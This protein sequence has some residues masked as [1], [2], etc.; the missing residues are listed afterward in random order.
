[1]ISNIACLQSV[2]FCLNT[3]LMLRLSPNMTCTVISK[4]LLCWCWRSSVTRNWGHEPNCRHAELWYSSNLLILL[5]FTSYRALCSQDLLWR[6]VLCCAIHL[7]AS[8]FTVT[9]A[10]L[11]SHGSCTPLLSAFRPAVIVQRDWFKYWAVP[12]DENILSSVQWKYQLASRLATGVRWVAV[13]SRQFCM[14]SRPAV[15]W[16][17]ASVSSRNPYLT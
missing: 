7:L 15:S 12:K 5:T 9:G 6:A 4:E 17:I 14:A 1:M 10:W 11:R 8:V 16:S 2:N 13:S 3:I